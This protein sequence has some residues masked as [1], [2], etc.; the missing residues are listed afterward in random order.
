MKK[1]IS[2]IILYISFTTI[3]SQ[4]ILFDLT[5]DELAGN[6]D[7]TIGHSP[8]WIGGISDFGQALRNLGYTTNTLNGNNITN[9]DLS[10]CD[11][12]VIPEPQNAFSQ[13]EKSAIVNFV[14]NGGGLLLIGDHDGADRNNNGWDAIHIFNETL[15]IDTNFGFSF[16]YD[17]EWQDPTNN[18][19]NPRTLITENVNSVGMWGGSTINT[20]TNG[21]CHI[22]LDNNHTQ[23]YVV[24][25]IINQGKVVAMGDSSPFD[26]GT[27]NPGNNLYDG[28]NDL[29]DAQLGVNII[30]WLLTNETNPIIISNI[31]SNPIFPTS[32]DDITISCNVSSPN[33]LNPVVLHWKTTGAFTTTVMNFSNNAYSAI[34]PSQPNLTDISYYISASDNSGNTA[35]APSN[36]PN[37]YFH[38]VIG[39]S[40]DIYNIQ[41]TNNSDDGTYPS[42]FEG[43]SVTV[44]GVVTAINYGNNSIYISDPCGGEWHGICVDN[45][46]G[47]PQI[48]DIVQLTGIVSEYYGF[49]KIINLTNSEIIGS[50]SPILPTVV[51]TSEIASN[52]SLEGVFCRIEN[53]HVTQSENNYNE[54]YCS[55]N[56]SQCQIDDGIYQYPG[57]INIGDNFSSIMGVVDYAYGE[58]SLNPRSIDDFNT[59]V[60]NM[61]NTINKIFKLFPNPF[62]PS[63]TFLQFNVREN[64]KITIYNVKGQK[65]KSLDNKSTWNGKDFSGKIVSNGIYFVKIC[66]HKK[67]EIRKVMVLK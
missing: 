21:T 10:N 39:N 33:S 49:T 55:D 66:S 46:E 47:N 5:K 41:F 32:E 25:A 17:N 38:I 51:T 22:W 37:S 29:D 60:S 48:G 28:W 42:D 7:W 1:M 19:E 11:V 36:V 43:Q 23:P 3:F 64:S 45:F 34:I 30:N 24:S 62:N 20:G 26:D 13:S 61:D 18:I 53:V 57:N 15:D 63:K 27:G 31:N 12:F 14:Q 44:H 50:Q 35:T 2:I 67:M 8:N 54:W 40:N 56:T 58:Y 65:I 52:E 16:N 4:T 6:A 59:P 9:S